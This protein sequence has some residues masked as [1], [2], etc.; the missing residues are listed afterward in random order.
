MSIEIKELDYVA[1]M[2]REELQATQGGFGYYF[3]PLNYH[4][5]YRPVAPINTFAGALNHSWAA[6]GQAFDNSFNN[7]LS[8]F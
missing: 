7:W 1:E 3:Y 4:W 8:N 2:S 5:L 6:R